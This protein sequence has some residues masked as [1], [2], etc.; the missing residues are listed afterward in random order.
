MKFYVSVVFAVIFLAG[1]S[2]NSAFYYPSNSD[3]IDRIS[4]F[5]D[6]QEFWLNSSS[7]N[8]LNGHLYK[9]SIEPARGVILH[10]HGNRG[11]QSISYK[12][13]SWLLNAGYDIVSFDY[14]GYGRSAGKP[15]PEN[16]HADGL[17]ALRFVSSLSRAQPGYRKIVW[18][19]SLGGVILSDSFSA[20]TDQNEFDLVIIESAFHSYQ[21]QASYIASNS[22]LGR[23][24]M[25]AIPHIVSDTYAPAESVRGIEGSRFLFVHCTKD[26]IVPIKFGKR[27][28]DLV[29]VS[30][31]FWEVSGCKHARPFG[32]EF[33]QRRQVLLSLLQSPSYAGI[34]E[35]NVELPV[36]P[37][38]EKVVERS[39]VSELRKDNSPNPKQ[40]DTL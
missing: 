27:L 17:A 11:D 18:G 3:E 21:E 4:K 2:T 1:C 29:P 28:Y 14:S 25:W 7:G 24:A 20:F 32:E 39:L 22:I 13:L 36:D 9:T 33:V 12:K 31:H 16:T 6:V 8:R 23:L 38:D 26:R 5:A 10:F 35:G 37:A 15:S 19:T 34:F 40:V 30:K